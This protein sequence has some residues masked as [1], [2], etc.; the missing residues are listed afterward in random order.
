MVLRVPGL[1]YQKGFGGHFHNDN[2]LTIFRDIPG[3]ILAVPSNGAD[4]VRMLRTAV[5]EA[6]HNG[7]VVVFIEPIALYMTKDLYHEKDGKWVFEYPD[8]EEEL[9]LGEFQTYGN[10]KTLTIITYG[11]GLYLSLQAQKE[12]EKKIKKKT[13][14][15]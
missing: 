12:I 2:S 6:Y 9:P 14:H 11:N 15:S 7:R 1:A 5:K 4:A 3:I 13:Q 8:V 10:G